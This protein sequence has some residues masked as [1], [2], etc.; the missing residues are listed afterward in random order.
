MNFESPKP[1]KTPVKF[2]LNQIFKPL[3]KFAIRLGAACTALSLAGF[4][5]PMIIDSDPQFAKVMAYAG[6]SGVFLS[7]LF[8]KQK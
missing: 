2:G 5:M 8:G 6:L 7:S 4:A 1:S 3:P